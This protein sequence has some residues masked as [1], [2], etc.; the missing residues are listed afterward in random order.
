MGKKPRFALA[1]RPLLVRRPI[2]VAAGK[3]TTMNCCPPQAQAPTCPVINVPTKAVSPMTVRQHA[4]LP[5]LPETVLGFCDSPGCDVVYVG[6]DGTLIRKAQLR[7]RV[8]VKETDDPIPV[9][10]CFNF[11]ARQVAEDVMANGHSTIRSYIEE[12]VRA[13][14]CR[15]ETTNPAGRCCL[16][17]LS[18]VVS[19]ALT[20]PT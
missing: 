5:Q 13:G 3:E 10:Y 19:Q 4:L 6:A 15:C 1:A 20:Q 17:N 16:G 2:L 12:Q 8:G 11:T 18:R 7:T 9:C 14:R